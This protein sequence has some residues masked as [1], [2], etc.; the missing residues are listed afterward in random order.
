MAAAA[1][2]EPPA[3]IY[4]PP[5]GAL[6]VFDLVPGKFYKMYGVTRNPSIAPIYSYWDVVKFRKLELDDSPYYQ[7]RYFIVFNSSNNITNDRQS[8]VTTTDSPSYLFY[9][10]KTDMG[11]NRFIGTFPPEA[12]AQIQQETWNRRKNAVTAYATKHNNNARRRKNGVSR[13]RKMSRR[14]K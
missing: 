13:K 11:E 7:N 4:P 2:P 6:S 5:E 3:V 14:R 10:L 1:A 12:M 9:E 8:V